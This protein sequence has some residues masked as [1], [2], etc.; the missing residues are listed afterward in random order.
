MSVSGRASPN[1]PPGAAA[2]IPKVIRYACT[3][4][5]GALHIMATVRGHSYR[6]D[7]TTTFVARSSPI[8]KPR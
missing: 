2:T 5:L 4:G 1:V 6:A 8:I 3:A 7:N